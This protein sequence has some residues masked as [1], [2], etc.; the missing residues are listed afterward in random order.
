MGGEHKIVFVGK[1]RRGVDLQEAAAA[2][3]QRFGIAEDKARRALEANREL[4]LKQGLDSGRA[5]RY[6]KALQEIG[7]EFRVEPPLPG[8]APPGLALETLE[9]A[10]GEGAAGAE[11]ATPTCPKCGSSR[12]EDGSCLDCGIVIAKYHARHSRAESAAGEPGSA[13]AGRVNN[14]YAAPHADLGRAAS[15]GQLSGP[16]SVPFGHG[17]TWL[18]RGFWHLRQN[19]GVWILALLA[20]VGMSLVLSLVP[21]V[22]SI[23]VTMISP[24]IVAGF[25]IGAD[26]Q[27][28]G[29]DFE[30]ACL[31]AG[32]SR[33]A[34]QLLLVGL[35]Y[36]VGMIVIGVIVFAML[37][38][39][40]A[41]LGGMGALE[42]GDPAIAAAV[43]TSP[44]LLLASLVG[45]AIAVPLLMA[46]WFAP[47]LVALSDLSALSAMR[48]SFVGCLKNILPFLLYGL[49]GM[50]L[51]IVGALPFGLGL[52]IVLPMIM[53]SIYTGYRDIYYA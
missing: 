15:E 28:Q 26:A 35:L 25:M 30:F 38:G 24:V 43:L 53:A 45:F 39:T 6:A 2:F 37:V 5:A 21:L 22:G 14:P 7:M 10:A 13:A 46:Y 16:V 9:G 3:A 34:G 20:W 11:P 36:L 27:Q 51:V 47:P 44:T 17:W 33:N 18:A 49:A 29:D 52:L 48:L 42:T 50:L 31:F 23:V 4:V 12:I 41:G 40:F 19:P 1:L 32:F 8:S